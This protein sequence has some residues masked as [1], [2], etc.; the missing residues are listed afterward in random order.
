MSYEVYDVD[1][2]K[3]GPNWYLRVF[4]DKEGGF[5]INDCV[6]FS[7]ALEAKLEENDPIETPYILEVSSPGLDRILKKDKDFMKNLGKQADIKLYQPREGLGRSFQA[8]LTDYDASRQM[9]TLTLED[10][11]RL[12]LSRKEISGIR[13][14]VIF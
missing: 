5:S 2:E 11:N 3:E 1:Y 12:E 13:L 14:A 8:E 9:V 10:G 6:D 4:M 7:H